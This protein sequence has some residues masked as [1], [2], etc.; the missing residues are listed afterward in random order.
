MQD[1]NLVSLVKVF[2]EDCI[3]EINPNILLFELK[4]RLADFKDDN[5][6]ITLSVNGKGSIIKELQVLKLQV[7]NILQNVPLVQ[8]IRVKFQGKKVTL[9]FKSNSQNF[10]FVT[11]YYS[12]YILNKKEREEF[13]SLMKEY[14]GLVILSK[15]RTSE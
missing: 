11:I 1:Q 9:S 8:Y 2:L 15:P 4:F 5:S 13:K 7:N 6:H 14:Y 12:E 10:E 3:S